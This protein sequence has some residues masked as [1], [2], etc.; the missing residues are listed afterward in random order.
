MLTTDVDFSLENDIKARFTTDK[1][2]GGQHTIIATV[3]YNLY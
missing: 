1:Y 3:I 2:V